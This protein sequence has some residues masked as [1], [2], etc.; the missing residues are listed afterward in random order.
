MISDQTQCLVL[1]HVDPCRKTVRRV[2]TPSPLHVLLLCATTDELHNNSSRREHLTSHTVEASRPRQQVSAGDIRGVEHPF[3]AHPAIGT[4]L[5]A[6]V[7]ICAAGGSV[8]PGM[9]YRRT[10]GDGLDEGAWTGFTWT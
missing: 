7:C 1:P 9:I 4:A 5:A 8:T 10:L 2:Q 6:L 3:A